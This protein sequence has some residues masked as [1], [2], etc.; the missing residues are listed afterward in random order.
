MIYGLLFGFSA[1]YA[2]ADSNTDVHPVASSRVMCNGLAF[3]LSVTKGE[4]GYAAE[5]AIWRDESVPRIVGSRFPILDT[6]LTTRNGRTR[7]YDQFGIAIDTYTEPRIIETNFVTSA[8]LGKSG[9]LILPLPLEK[10]LDDFGAK[11]RVKIDVSFMATKS[12]YS[13]LM[14][15]EFIRTS[16]SQLLWLGNAQLPTLVITVP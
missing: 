7:V 2:T 12:S 4:K 3:Q 9:K 6:R 10:M 5:L 1:L 15:K 8:S 11:G 16:T 13:D 14:W